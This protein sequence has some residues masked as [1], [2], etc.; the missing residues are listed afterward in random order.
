M[1]EGFGTTVEEA[2][3]LEKKILEYAPY[4]GDTG[5]QRTLDLEPREYVDLAYNDMVNLYERTQ[6]I[7]STTGLLG[8][9]AGETAPAEPGNMVATKEVES[10]LKEMTTETLKSAEEVGKEPIVLE[11]EVQPP[12]QPEQKGDLTIEF[13]TRPAT[14]PEA[15]KIEIEKPRL[16]ETEREVPEEEAKTTERQMEE[17]EKEEGEK[18][19]E[20]AGREEAK[21]ERE[22]QAAQAGR[23]ITEKP[24]A[25]KA[26]EIVAPPGAHMI[27]AA[28]PPAL[29]TSPDAMAS[30]KYAQME[31]Q[32][33]AAVG[34][35]ADE[36][37]LK[38]KMLELTKQL[39]KE[40]STSRR[41]EIK[42]Q[43]T[44]LKNMLSSQL[45]PT[46]RKPAAKAGG[47]E[48]HAKMFETLL[49]TQQTGLAQMKDGIIDSYNRQ[50]GTIKKK[51]Y[52]DI[53]A[54]DDPAERKKI[55]HSFSFSIESLVQQLPDVMD[56]YRD[57]TTTKHTAE[58][59]QLMASL[60]P[61]E[62]DVRKA[63]GE[64]LEYINSGYGQEFT[65]VTTLI[66][67]QLDNLID[68]TGAEILKPSGEGKRQTAEN[69]EYEIVK[70][71]N[72]MGE[73]M[74]LSYLRTTD[75]K[76]Y[77]AYELKKMSKAEAIFK[78]KEL[79]A[80]EKGLSQKTVKKY[81]THKE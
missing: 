75:P 16:Q 5:I 7:I 61:E 74:L 64:R 3:K 21:P 20:E 17:E 53:A 76:T 42:L 12:P 48:T 43:I 66:A 59:Q 50:I 24:L 51:F 33:R 40:K 37:T 49:S 29:K 1:E 56:K 81:F 8:S 34:E 6:K 57:F 10:R 39:F 79:M 14:A 18:R 70:E 78:A 23:R 19:A 4:T 28:V 65:A 11:R 77:K 36:L 58:L 60:G 15:E 68:I 73:G 9:M 32:V 22:E 69:K 47:D 54:T 46:G 63:V 44:V 41:E 38:K 30:R 72:E 52:D 13:E 45:R 2:R 71:I 35:K 25:P 62:K 31:E 80:N 26:E 27:V 67:H 55:Y